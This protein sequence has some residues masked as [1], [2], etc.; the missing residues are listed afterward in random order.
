MNLDERIW[1]TGQLR[2]WR[3]VVSVSGVVHPVEENAKVGGG[4]FVRVLLK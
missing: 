1:R 4:F 2:D 3:N